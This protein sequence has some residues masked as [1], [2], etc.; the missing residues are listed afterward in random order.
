M[1]TIENTLLIDQ[2]IVM[3]DE[4]F[5]VLDNLGENTASSYPYLNKVKNILKSKDPKG[6]P[7]VKSHLMMDFRM[8]ED[9]QLEG[10]ELDNAIN[11]VYHHVNSYD[12]FKK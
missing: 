8:I 4:L 3:M 6:L 5:L 7:N 9:R 1:H 11:V 12:I 10:N 2:L